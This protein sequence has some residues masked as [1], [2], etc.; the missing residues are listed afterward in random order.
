MNKLLI[1]KAKS[2][3]KLMRLLLRISN[4]FRPNFAQVIIANDH[5]ISSAPVV[6]C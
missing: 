1:L 6:L 5:S 3:H 4:V 2:S